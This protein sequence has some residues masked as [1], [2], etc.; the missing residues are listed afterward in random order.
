MDKPYQKQ[1]RDNNGQIL[2]QKC[3]KVNGK[4]VKSITNIYYDCLE[5]I[6]DFLDLESLLSLANTCKRL[7]IAA[8]V[9]FSDILGKRE[10]YLGLSQFNWKKPGIYDNGYLIEVFGLKYGLPLL[11]CFGLK[12]YG[13]NILYHCNSEPNDYV[14][15]YVNQY[16]ADTVKFIAF[17]RKP[18]FSPETHQKPF[19]CVERVVLQNVDVGKHLPSFVNWFPKLRQLEMQNIS[20][21]ENFIDI[22]FPHLEYLTA[23]VGNGVRSNFT[24][25]NILGLLH[26]NRQLI[27]LDVYM[28]DNG[29][30]VMSELFSMISENPM[31]STFS[32]MLNSGNMVAKVSV[33][34]MMRFAVEHPTLREMDLFQYQ[35][36]AKDAITFI[37]QIKSLEQLQFQVTDESEFER[38][39]NQ[40][41]SEWEHEHWTSCGLIVKLNRKN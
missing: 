33:I 3:Q 19:K 9:K 12:I 32:T 8:S 1:L 5:R 24:K 16:C 35:F 22:P 40:L 23:T 4:E 6:F 2:D 14:D 17:K 38:F 10:I 26:A 39:A 21:D 29:R 37:R 34:E 20:I 11:R 27:G 13:L 30:M 41:D 36:T 15:R 7:Q 18:K 31:I 25:K 28:H